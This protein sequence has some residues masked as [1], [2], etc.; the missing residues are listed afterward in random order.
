MKELNEHIED[1]IQ[2]NQSMQIAIVNLSMTVAELSA[3]MEDFGE[4]ESDTKITTG[5]QIQ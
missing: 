2:I 3:R 1:L 4:S 5:F